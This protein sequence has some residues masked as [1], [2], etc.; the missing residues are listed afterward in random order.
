MKYIALLV[1]VISCSPSMPEPQQQSQRQKQT[2][3]PTTASVCEEA[4]GTPRKCYSDEECCDGFS[5]SYDP[6][7][8]RRQKYCL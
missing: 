1:F 5:C 4:N 2:I 8:S 6:E 3:K 7:L